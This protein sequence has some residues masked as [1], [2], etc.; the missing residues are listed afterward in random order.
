MKLPLS[1]PSYITK[2]TSLRL[3]SPKPSFNTFRDTKFPAGKLSAYFEDFSITQ[4]KLIN[5]PEHQVSL[6]APA[7]KYKARKY[8][9]IFN[10]TTELKG[11]EKKQVVFTLPSWSFSSTIWEARSDFFALLHINS[12]NKLNFISLGTFFTCKW[13][14]GQVCLRLVGLGRGLLA[15]PSFCEAL[16]WFILENGS[17]ER[18]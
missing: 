10:K 13:R 2:E 18:I 6:G 3:L 16:L 15:S 1:S 5:K 4:Y 11:R 7:R 14:V 8:C 9:P 12:G 17:R